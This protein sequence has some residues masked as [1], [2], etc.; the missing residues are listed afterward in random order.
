MPIYRPSANS[1]EIQFAQSSFE[2]KRRY[3]LQESVRFAYTFDK[4]NLILY[5]LQLNYNLILPTAS[6]KFK[7]MFLGPIFLPPNVYPGAIIAFGGRIGSKSSVG[8]VE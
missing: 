2:R 7:L 3:Q 5:L 8:M 1:W 6:Q 4:Q